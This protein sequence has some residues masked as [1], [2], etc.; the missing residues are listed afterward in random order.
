MACKYSLVKSPAKVTL[1]SITG[2]AI[3]VKDIMPMMASYQAI[4]GIGPWTVF[5]WDSSVVSGRTYHGRPSQGSERAAVADVGGIRLT[6]VQPV[7]GDSIFRDFLNEQ[8]E[9]LHHVELPVADV[10]EAA[11]ILTGEGFPS[12]ASGFIGERDSGNAFN[13]I[14][15]EP[16]HTIWKLVRQ[17]A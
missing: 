11:E 8:G 15:I 13:Y 17:G 16:L 7:S 10:D 12:L 6:L 9:G 5:E 2:V 3:A 14:Y 1:K 4:L